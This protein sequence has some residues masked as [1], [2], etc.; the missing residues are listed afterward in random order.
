[1]R[2]AI[3]EQSLKFDGEYPMWHHVKCL[4]RAISIARECYSL[5]T[6]L[7]RR[8][9]K[10]PDVGNPNLLKGFSLLRPSDQPKI[11]KFTAAAAKLAPQPSSAATP[12]PTAT[13]TTSAPTT[14]TA[15][16]SDSASSKALSCD[17]RVEYAKSNRSKCVYCKTNIEKDTM[18]IGIKEQS[19]KFDGETYVWH[20]ITC[21]FEKRPNVTS[22]SYIKGFDLLRPS[23]QPKIK[24]FTDKA[25]KALGVAAPEEKKD[26]VME[27]GEKDEKPKKKAA[28]TRTTSSKKKKEVEKKKKK[29]K[30]ID[31]NTLRVADLKEELQARDLNTNG[32]KADLVRRLKRALRDEEDDEEEDEED[33]EEDEE[34]E[35]EEDEEEDEEEEEEEEEDDE[36]KEDG[37]SYI[38]K[39]WDLKDRLTRSCTTAQL[40]EALEKNS[41]PS[42]GGMQDLAHRVADCIIKGAIPECPECEKGALSFEDGMYV[43][44]HQATEWSSCQFKAKEGDVE[45]LPW[46]NPKWLTPKLKAAQKKQPAT[47]RKAPE[48]KKSVAPAKKRR[49]EKQRQD[50]SEDEERGPVFEDIIFVL[51]GDD[52]SKSQSEWKKII[53]KEGGEVAKKI[54]R[55]V[56][57][58]VASDKGVVGNQEQIKKAIDKG[59]PV[60]GEDFLTD[61]LSAGKIEDQSL[62]RLSLKQIEREEEDDPKGKGKASASQSSQGSQG[63]QPKRSR[64]EEETGRM[65][66]VRKG[67]AAV[68]PYYDDAENVHVLEEGD[69]IYNAMLNNTDITVGQRGRNSFYALQLLEHDKKPIW[70]VFRRWG[71]VGLEGTQKVVE[72]DDRDDAIAEFETVYQDK[73]YNSWEKRDNFVKRPGK[74]YPVAVDYGTEEKEIKFADL[75][76]ATGSSLPPQVQGLVSLLFD[77]QMMKNTLVEMEIDLKKMPLG[78][79]TKEQIKDG[80]EALTEIQNALD[81]ASRSATALLDSTNKFYTIVPHDFGDE[82]PPL[83]DNTDLLKKKLE[84]LDTLQEIEIATSLLKTDGD[85]SNA[86]DESYKKLKTEIV[87]LD[88]STEEYAT[89]KRYAEQGH[90]KRYFQNFDIEVLE[91]FKIA[92]EGAET[93]FAPWSRNTNRQL[94]WHGSRLTNFVGILSQGLRI[95]PPEAP[96]TGY[97]FGKGVYFADTVS[98]SGSYC[99]TS[100]SNPIGLMLLNEVALGMP[101]ELLDDQY[102]ERPLPGSHSTKA[103]GATAP[104]PSETCGKPKPTGIRSSCSHNEYIVYS[105]DQISMRYLLKMQF[106]HKF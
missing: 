51:L 89:L 2:I 7:F 67:R 87:P 4:V 94:L 44:H 34:E 73:T 10:R 100:K 46:K 29:K 95:A 1:M 6:I 25:A 56:R 40:K 55:D 66:V 106:N 41:Q 99:F 47:K 31:P 104:D 77:I 54:S 80:Y 8:T 27:E 15:S 82:K 62:Y 32:L 90:D 60:V 79:L 78:K 98:K 68:D 50:S 76:K 49:V 42:R 23:D 16:S 52:M 21:F 72:H 85:S 84:L 38:D 26:A 61:S 17:F 22:V 70:F 58:I 37:G 53:G 9:D 30:K 71:R 57:Y 39:L 43:C 20:H 18:R 36:Q 11:K 83:I 59:I 14:T 45:R 101:K 103:M 3:I 88:S 102:M 92:R 91:I 12:T 69:T 81:S 24:K 86:I 5:L 74:F 19:T 105:T 96:K 75:S 35:E 64:V 93:T 33:A 28:T 97:R 65:K 63:S 13:T 48:P